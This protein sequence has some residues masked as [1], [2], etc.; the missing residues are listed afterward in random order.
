MTTTLNI[1]TSLTQT[2]TNADLGELANQNKT[3]VEFSDGSGSLSKFYLNAIAT[4]EIHSTP[5]ELIVYDTRKDSDGGAWRKRT[6]HC[7]W[8]NEPLNTQTR[9]KRREFPSVAVIAF[10]STT[11]TIYDGDDPDL[12]MW[13]V[14]NSYSGSTGTT[15]YSFQIDVAIALFHQTQINCIDALNGKLFVGS[16]NYQ[17][18]F[19]DFAADAIGLYT[20][21]GDFSAGR[22]LFT[23]G[24][25]GR[26]LTGSYIRRPW[27]YTIHSSTIK[28]I[29]LVSLPGAS[30]EKTSG[31]ASVT[32]AC[33]SN[34]GLFVIGAD[35]EDNFGV[36]GRPVVSKY[37][38]NSTHMMRVKWVKSFD[39]CY[40]LWVSTQHVSGVVGYRF[41]NFNQLQATSSSGTIT[42]TKFWG[43]GSSE[44]SSFSGG[45]EPGGGGYFNLLTQS[46]PQGEIAFPFYGVYDG[47]SGTSKYS[48]LMRV[49]NRNTR[50]GSGSN[51]I[52]TCT[53]RCNNFSGWLP[54]D[55]RN[56]VMTDTLSDSTS[57][58]GTHSEAPITLASSWTGVSQWTGTRSG[59]VSVAGGNV[60]IT[61]A[62]TGGSSWT[63]GIATITK[64][65]PGKTY[66]ASITPSS[67]SGND[68]YFWRTLDSGGAHTELRYSSTAYTD[69]ID[70]SQ[71]A[72]VGGSTYRLVWTAK[73]ETE[74]LI[75]EKSGASTGATIVIPDGGLTVT[76]MVA[77]RSKNRKHAVVVGQLTRR[78]V[79]SNADLLSYTNFR[80]D[81]YLVVPYH[82]SLAPADSNFYVMGWV[83]SNQNNTQIWASWRNSSGG[84]GDWWQMWSTENQIN[85]GGVIGGSSYITSPTNNQWYNNK[86]HFVVGVRLNNVFRLY[87]DGKDIGN[88]SISNAGTL[89]TTTSHRLLYGVHHDLNA[90]YDHN[91]EMALWRYG[92]GIVTKDD[93]QKIYLDER[94]LFKANAKCGLYGNNNTISAIAY[95]DSTDLLHVGTSAGR[96]TF[97]GLV[98]VEN[99]TTSTTVLGAA[100]GLVVE[101]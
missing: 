79:A 38:S 6:Q 49:D 78:P 75:V 46:S 2:P 7:S 36:S 59:T 89:N 85:W 83:K 16:E 11:V 69:W 25:G 71:T 26:H 91:S 9:G 18:T 10:T 42:W 94:E 33:I 63:G 80:S 76:E 14:I 68:W 72:M 28:S 64:L 100:G 32:V 54:A 13:M 20:E 44:P 3:S 73:Q 74:Y 24:I 51:N 21:Y 37:G 35:N 77:D 50:K 95:D 61:S 101:A 34:A 8:Y 57:N 27:G 4:K 66:V 97:K 87:L 41:F 22:A 92:P 53:H 93:V 67:Q 86:W 12:P 19:F 45:E 96:S 31:M 99:T 43:A 55:V 23:N 62:A 30:I 48:G 82:S 70:T 15:A 29:S 1:G 40:E 88:A 90:S 58:N 98:R 39:G 65:I 17:L 56:A 84:S 60:T 47:I 52:M 5:T 81:K